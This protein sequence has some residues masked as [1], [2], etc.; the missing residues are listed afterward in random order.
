MSTLAVTLLSIL[1]GLIPI[2]FGWDV[3]PN[4][5][6]NGQDISGSHQASSVE[7]CAD[8]CHTIDQCVATSWNGPDSRYHDNNCNLKCGSADQLTITGEEAVIVRP[9]ENHC[10]DGP[11]PPAK[12]KSAWYKADLLWSAK[13]NFKSNLAATLGNGYMAVGVTGE[14]LYVAGVF[15]GADPPGK[16]ITHR[17]ALPN[18]VNRLPSFS[19]S[20]VNGSALSLRNGSYTRQYLSNSLDGSLEITMYAHRKHKSIIVAEAIAYVNDGSSVSV[21]FNNIK[22]SSNDFTLTSVNK[23]ITLSGGKN[24]LVT[25]ITGNT[26]VPELSG[27]KTTAVAM[28]TRIANT[29]AFDMGNR[30]IQ[31]FL[32]SIRTS[33]DSDDPEKDATNDYISA[34]ESSSTLYQEHVEQWSEIWKSGFEIEGRLDVARVTNASLYYIISSIREDTRYSL[35]PGGL[36]SNGYNGHTFWDCETWMYPSL[37]LWHP[38]IAASILDYRFQRQ[39]EARVKAKS[40]K[41]PYSGTMFPWES[42]LMG[43]EACPSWASTGEF[44]QH[45]SGDIAFAAMQYW[46]STGDLNWLKTVGYPL[47]EGIA[48]FWVSKVQHDTH[49]DTWH[50]NHVIPPDEYALGDDCVYTNYVA[51]VSLTFATEAASI[52]GQ[53]PDPLWANIS[54]GLVILFDNNQKIHPEYKG[55]GGKKIKQADVVLL[56]YPLGMKMPAEV[57][58]NDLLYYAQR[59]DSGGPAMTWGMHSVGFLEIGDLKS[60]S[61]NFDRSFAN[62]QQPFLVW[63]ETPTGGTTNFLTG[64]GGYLQTVLFGY[65][66]IRIQSNKLDANPILIDGAQRVGVHG[67]H[68][69][70]AIFSMVYDSKVVTFSLTEDKNSDIPL[71]VTDVKTGISKNMSVDGIVFDYGHQ[72][73]ITRKSF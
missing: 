73:N 56:G 46:R 12:W 19:G 40:Y 10:H 41:P 44:E 31:Y 27:G 51:K 65:P 45:I 50:I 60:A 58:K 23:N 25:V 59:T 6:F 28:V 71:I 36:A 64:A 70:N 67:I 21:H 29:E 35:S 33:L 66:G 14:P 8:Y 24:V 39:D 3:L 68:Y 52:V 16:P 34:L 20:Y 42:A 18:F 62:A 15:N 37:V 57:R 9:G 55:Y 5:D 30:D 11:S 22:A 72:F 7:E 2:A 48:K 49:N 17:A 38:E 1:I 63:T 32:T 26:K 61:S 4:T 53:T 69:Q 54:S 13:D 43:S 47:V